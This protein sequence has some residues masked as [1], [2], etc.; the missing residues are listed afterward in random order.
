MTTRFIEKNFAEPLVQ[1]KLSEVETKLVEK[2][3]QQ[4]RAQAAG[5]GASG[6]QAGLVGGDGLMNS[7][8]LSYWRGV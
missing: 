7:P 3:L 1:P 2:A 5:A 4:L 6:G 8:W